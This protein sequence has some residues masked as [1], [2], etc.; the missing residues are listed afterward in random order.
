MFSDVLEYYWYSSI[1]IRVLFLS[2]RIS[3]PFSITHTNCPT[4]KFVS[5]TDLV[6][7]ILTFLGNAWLYKNRLCTSL[8]FS[9]ELNI[10]VLIVLALQF[11]CHFST[12]VTFRTLYCLFGIA[13]LSIYVIFWLSLCFA[14]TLK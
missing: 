3:Y 11:Y 10:K 8:W 5:A 7:K 12:A 2:F 6:C 1:G 4:A 9:N 13:V 14:L